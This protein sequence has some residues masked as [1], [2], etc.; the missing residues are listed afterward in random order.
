[1]G[2]QARCETIRI[3]TQESLP[4]N[5]KNWSGTQDL[6]SWRERR[7]VGM[8]EG[9]GR[10][11]TPYPFLETPC[12]GRRS[13]DPVCSSAGMTCHRVRRFAQRETSWC[14]VCMSPDAI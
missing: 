2:H 10:Q 8:T 13:S 11:V 12:H 9:I 3:A 1:M 7:K 5:L 14:S 6:S 4:E